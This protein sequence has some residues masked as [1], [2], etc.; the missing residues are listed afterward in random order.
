VFLRHFGCIFTHE[1]T[2]D[3][4]FDLEEIRELGS[5][6]VFVGSGT[7]KQTLKFQ[8][9]NLLPMQIFVDPTLGVYREAGLVRS[10]ASTLNWQ[11]F[12]NMQRARKSGH[13]TTRKMGDQWQQGGCFVITPRQ[14]VLYHQV[15]QVAGDHPSKEKVL[16]ALSARQ[17][18]LETTSE[19]RRS[20]ESRV[21]F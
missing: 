3:F 11:S 20:P 18:D 13:R 12:L 17:R 2:T 15:S 5:D 4:R 8:E 10:L 7:P 21:I 6:V 14:R 1:L 19:I 16:T 9:K